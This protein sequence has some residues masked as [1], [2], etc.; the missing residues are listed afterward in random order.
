MLPADKQLEASLKSSYLAE[1]WIAV[2]HELYSWNLLLLRLLLMKTNWKFLKFY[3]KKRKV[4][5][6]KLIQC[7]S[8]FS[9]LHSCK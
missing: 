4:I 9:N 2:S 1:V 5:H 6:D 8:R 7:K 3:I